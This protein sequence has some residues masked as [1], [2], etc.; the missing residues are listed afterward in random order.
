MELE[1]WGVLHICCVYR[2]EDEGER[3]RGIGEDE[4]SGER[5][6]RKRGKSE[7]GEELEEMTRRREGEEE[8]GGGE[9]GSRKRR[10]KRR[11]RR[12]SGSESREREEQGPSASDEQQERP[13]TPLATQTSHSPVPPLQTITPGLIE[14]SIGFFPTHYIVNTPSHQVEK[15]THINF[16]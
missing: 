9:T 12:E 5:R 4:V 7:E 14:Q 15:A 10:R 16:L 6:R 2:V 3:S 13:E 1:V 11:T 8:G